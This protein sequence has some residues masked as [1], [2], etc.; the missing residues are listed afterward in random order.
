MGKEK[1][2]GKGREGL[3]PPQT[4]IPGAATGR[5]YEMFIAL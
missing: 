2:E 4:L 3:Q 5:N 1:G